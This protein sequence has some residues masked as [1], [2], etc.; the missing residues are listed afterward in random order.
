M[1][2][3]EIMKVYKLYSFWLNRDPNELGLYYQ[4]VCNIGT[5]ST[6]EKAEEY[7]EKGWFYF[8]EHWNNACVIQEWELDKP[9]EQQLIQKTIKQ[10]W[11]LS[12]ENPAEEIPKLIDT[13]NRMKWN[14][15][16]QEVIL[17]T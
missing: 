3:E 14:N 13:P 1:Y 15:E 9:T 7:I 11:Y 12:E 16:R 5:F 10:W 2:P 17:G 8:W 4:H 6:K